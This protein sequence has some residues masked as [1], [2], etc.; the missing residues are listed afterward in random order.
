MALFDLQLPNAASWVYFS[1]IL[2][3]AVFF[4]FNRPFATRN[5]DILGLYLFAPGFLHLQHAHQLASD[6]SA[7]HLALADS[8]RVL[9]Y[10]W[11]LAASFLWFIR[12]LLDFVI[13]RRPS[14]IPNLG[15][16][17]LIW[18]GSAL[19]ILLLG[20]ALV[21]PSDPWEPVGRRPAA[22]AGVESGAAAIAEAT[23]KPVDEI[24]RAAISAGLASI[25]H[26]AIIAGLW[27]I[28]ARHF[29][30]RS[31][32]IAMAFAYILVPYT[33]FRYAVFHLALPS[34]L[35]LWAFVAY[36]RFTASGL[37]LGLAAGMAFFPL[38]L[39]PA[40]LQFYRGRGMGRFILW[41]GVGLIAGALVTTLGLWAIG[42]SWSQAWRAANPGDWIPWRIPAS[43]SIWMGSH[44]AYRLPVFV[45]YAA[46][47]GATFVWPVCRDFGQLVATSAAVLLGIQFWYAD[48]GGMYV[49]WYLPLLLLM[50]FRP[51]T[52]ELQPPPL[53]GPSVVPAPTVSDSSL[54]GSLS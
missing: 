48:Q 45:A 39:L 14:V 50:A 15:I 40:W 41:F 13:T 37:L 38:L 2:A 46:F 52:R 51:G 20:G 43:E 3:V 24:T 54:S 44:W 36:R 7:E 23:G 16:P 33:G 17:S 26:I 11:L 49:L 27:T 28:G 4:Q 53:I 6:L 5:R 10:T 21:R 30:N 34:A 22:M 12:C 42:L 8:E 47:V 18:L 19:L 25:G 35:I 1:F 32:G 31:I 29:Q 9:A